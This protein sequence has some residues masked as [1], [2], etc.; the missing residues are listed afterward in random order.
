MT[1]ESPTLRDARID[2]PSLVGAVLA[3]LPR[4]VLVT[5]A[6]LTITFVVLMFQPRLYESS[7]SILVEP[8][9]SAYLRPSV[10]Q[11]SAP[12]AADAGV[13]SSQIELIKSRDTL[14][15]VIDRLDLQSK[16]EFNGTDAGFSPLSLLTQMMG[17][18]AA[19]PSVDEVALNTLYDRLTVIQ[20][21]DSRII[22]VLVRSS[23][24]QLA[25]DIANAI[26][27]AHVARRA[28]L[29]L[30]DTAEA[31][32]WLGEEIARLRS[33]VN[34]A[35]SAVAQFKVD[36]DLYMGQNNTTLIDQQLST[37]AQQINAAQER[38][39]T[40]Q[41]RATLIRGLLDRAQP[42]E[43]VPDVR[44]SA[45]VQQLSEQ[46]ARLQAEKA[47]LSATLLPNHPTIRAMTA[48][49][50]EL[51]NQI[52][53]EGRR[54]ASALDAEAQIEEGII[55]SLQDDMVRTKVDASTAT[56]DGVTLDAL[57]REAKA[58]RDLLESYLARYNEAS[59]TV[60]VNSALP[61]VRV[62][63]VA[64]PAVSPA[65][66]KTSLIM[67]AVGLFGLAVQIGATIFGELMSGRAIIETVRE[68]ERVTEFDAPADE[69]VEPA[70]VLDQNLQDIPD[71]DEGVYEEEVVAYA[72]V[73]S[74]ANE[75]VDAASAYEPD[76]AQA[77]PTDETADDD[78]SEWTHVPAE[79]ELQTTEERLSFISQFEPAATTEPEDDA[80]V[81]PAE[82]LT[83]ARAELAR[84]RE[85]IKARLGHSNG[86]QDAPHIAEL[87]ATG[88][89]MSPKAASPI[90]KSGMVRYSDLAADLV[91]GRTHLL[92]LADHGDG[93]PSQHLADNLVGDALA[94]GLSVAL[95]DAGTGR[96]S[97]TAGLTDLS[98]GDAS[99]GDV[100]Q[101]SSDNSYAEV[102]WG[103]GES[104]DR[105]SAKPATLVEALGDIYE[106]VVVLTGKLGRN[107]MLAPFLDLGGR[108][109]MV[110]GEGADMEAAASAR[111][112]LMEAGVPLV[113][114]AASADAMAA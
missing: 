110:A 112:R 89:P 8:R 95:V 78:H 105:N 113:E 21:R 80:V 25:A 84:V 86:I 107:S 1:Y 102:P 88:A 92:L 55:A 49:I 91:L 69:E 30:A 52:Q 31:S 36:N 3:K 98:S 104:I 10:A 87:A 50:G 58:Q 45:V 57:Q 74:L 7:A 4:I 13:V 33:A 63:S 5:L 82:D 81:E 32:G 44:D 40:A 22:S 14:M 108:V 34:D 106:V 68:Q 94:K 65:S 75:Y 96:I 23:D 19:S 12:S 99:F 64:A 114:I 76:V 28:Q 70:E 54:V 51:D 77:D 100:V 109:V 60:N 39:N 41:S 111:Q 103:F 93:L 26:A 97:E 6:L 15:R 46:K 67:M 29:T 72:D 16:P 24:P 53:A 79:A 9:A 18:R 73:H 11:S 48:Q 71:Q 2:V 43:G 17:R 42:V 37:I 62:V 35:E 61:D 90:P 101:K 83:A 66:P 47:Q 27:N 20:E 85:F 56:R 38:K 59:S